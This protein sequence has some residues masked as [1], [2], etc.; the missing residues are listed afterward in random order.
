MKM[1]HSARETSLNAE[2]VVEVRQAELEG[3]FSELKKQAFYKNSLQREECGTEP[4]VE[5]SQR[6][7]GS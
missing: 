5:E 2:V 3:S 1:P 4:L 7:S 6:R